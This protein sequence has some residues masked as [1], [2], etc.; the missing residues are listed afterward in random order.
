MN[1]PSVVEIEALHKKYAPT[2][3]AFAEIWEHC[4]IVS[5]IATWCIDNGSLI[6]AD[7]ALVEVGSLLHDIGVYKLY[8]RAGALEDDNYITHG[9]LGYQILKDEGFSEELSRFA[10]HHTGVGI[11]A[12]EIKKNGL[13]LP[14][15]DFFADTIEERLVMY[16][17]K[18]HS[19]DPSQF[20]SCG[21]YMDHLSKKLGQDKVE[22]FQ[23]MV[24][25]FGEPPIEN[26]AQIYG[27]IVR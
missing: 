25:E 11:T 12:D 23:I 5:S 10:S 1:L 13:P 8:T 9:V 21:W 7:K 20:N 16:A 14:E 22:Q 6:S 27:Q 4:Q 2:D 24:T 18:F 19:K 26:I 15:E 3:G 17:D